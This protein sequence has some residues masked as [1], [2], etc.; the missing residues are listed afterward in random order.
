M[1]LHRVQDENA[2]KNKEMYMLKKKYDKPLRGETL[3]NVG[4]DEILILNITLDML[5]KYS[6]CT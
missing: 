6:V 5:N 1:V 2:T 3:F 4:L